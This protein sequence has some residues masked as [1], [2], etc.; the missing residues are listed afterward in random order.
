MA[1]SNLAVFDWRSRNYTAV[2]NVGRF[3]IE[4]DTPA[5]VVAEQRALRAAQH[6]NLIDVE[7]R[8]LEDRFLEHDVVKTSDTGFNASVEVG[9]RARM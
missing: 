7:Y 5:G 1:A 6:F 3:R 2:W 9:I 4:L 8:S